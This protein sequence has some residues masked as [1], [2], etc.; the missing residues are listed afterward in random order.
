MDRTVTRPD[1][2]ALLGS[3]HRRGKT[4]PQGVPGRP[5]G[6]RK[7]TAGRSECGSGRTET[8][9]GVSLT[10]P[11]LW[12]RVRGFPKDAGVDSIGWPKLIVKAASGE[13]PQW[14]SISRRSIAVSMT[15]AK[16]SK[17]GK[18]TG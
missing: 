1:G 2:Q 11:Q 18:R 12:I 5:T 14:P 6:P 16:C 8:P 9:C 13:P 7:D 15:S 4:S 3:Q 17:T 10:E